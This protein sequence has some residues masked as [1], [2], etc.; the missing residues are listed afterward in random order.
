MADLFLSQIFIRC[1]NL[2]WKL[3]ESKTGPGAITL[4]ADFSE[5]NIRCYAQGGDYRYS[6]TYHF[7]R[8]ELMAAG[9][10]YCNGYNAA[11]E[12][13]MFRISVTLSVVNLVSAY[14]GDTDVINSTNVAVFYR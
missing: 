1:S 7:V 14:L 13:A 2:E 10:F 4:P 3:G 6:V 5:L 11:G 8:D 12:I 9:M